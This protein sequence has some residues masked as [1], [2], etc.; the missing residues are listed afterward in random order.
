MFRTPLYFA[1]IHYPVLNKQGEDISTAITN[2]DLHDGSRL[3][4][5]FGLTRYF[6]VSPIEEQR[7][8]V[9]R[10]RDH[11]ITGRG[12]R[13]NPT[14]RQGMEKV[15]HA[16]DLNEVCETITNEHHV[17][18]LLVGTSAQ[19][20][21]SQQVS[22]E[23]LRK[24]IQDKDRPILLLFG[25]G[26]GISSNITPDI[27]IFLPPIYGPTDYNHLSVRAAMAITLDRLVGF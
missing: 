20:Q 17:K 22:Y 12:A 9:A 26:H 3:A 19:A 18:P 10:I 23:D 27:D 4:A 5:T 13:K 25:T 8:L 14:R 15:L 16:Y 6:L 1:L 11:W 21:E 2:L 7:G 24:Q